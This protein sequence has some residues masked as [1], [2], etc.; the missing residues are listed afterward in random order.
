M[1]RIFGGQA[2]WEGAKMLIKSSLVGILV[3]AA[4]RS[5]LPL[6]G[7]LVPI[8]LVLEMVGDHAQALI[9]NIALAGL[10]M[11]G[12]DYLMTRR[13]I[14][15]QTRMTKEEV[16]QEHKQSEGDPMLKSARR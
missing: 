3:Y 8:S 2:L 12:A 15:K 6:L 4:V 11:A 1:K 13:R 9:R 10:V 7:G 5:M 14:G 16:R